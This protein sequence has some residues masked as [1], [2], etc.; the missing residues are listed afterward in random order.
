MT[1]TLRSRLP[2]RDLA[3]F[4]SRARPKRVEALPLNRARCA[5]S[6]R[7]SLPSP[8]KDEM[9][10]IRLYRQRGRTRGPAAVVALKRHCVILPIVTKDKAEAN[11]F[12]LNTRGVQ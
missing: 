7:K 9:S 12:V 6:D 11:R 1:A 10:H 8:P 3:A 5:K 4:G 2:D